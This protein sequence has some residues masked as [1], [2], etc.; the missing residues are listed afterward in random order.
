MKN[1]NKILFSIYASAVLMQLFKKQRDAVGLT[2]YSNEIDDHIL[3]KTSDRHHQIIYKKFENIFSIM[4]NYHK[5]KHQQFH[6]CMKIA[7]RINQRSLIVL[8][9]DLIDDNSLDDIFDA[10]RHLK[11]K[12]NE[13]ILFYLSDVS[14]EKYLSLKINHIIL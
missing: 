7:D 1:P 13:V 6:M 3:S 12:K 2:T 10:F 11:H 9:T 4:Q 8:F 14:K 5:K